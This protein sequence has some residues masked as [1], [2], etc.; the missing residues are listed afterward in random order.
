MAPNMIAAMN[1]LQMSTAELNHM[2]EEKLREQSIVVASGWVGPLCT[3]ELQ[4]VRGSSGE[5]LVSYNNGH[6]PRLSLC[7]TPAQLPAGD[8]SDGEKW[9]IAS[10]AQ[11]YE[12]VLAV[13]SALMAREQE[14]LES[15]PGHIEHQVFAE[16]AG[17]CGLHITTV[18]RAVSN[19]SIDT[20]WG[21]FDLTVF[22]RK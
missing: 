13:A 6:P 1:V 7:E 11:R 9:F 3:P 12:I 21:A 14:F 10:I 18:G 2:I 16:V 15:G 4:V 17:D 22:F 8:S 5:W 20:P 19:K